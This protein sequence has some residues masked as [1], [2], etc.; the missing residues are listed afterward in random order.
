MAAHSTASRL[1]KSTSARSVGGGT[2]VSA[3]GSW[4]ESRDSGTPGVRYAFGVDVEGSRMAPAYGDLVQYG[5][6]DLLV[7]VGT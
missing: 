6:G 3:C 4:K 1:A 7:A 2:L 5:A